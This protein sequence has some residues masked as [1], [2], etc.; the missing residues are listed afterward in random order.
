M[1]KEE[2]DYEEG[3]VDQERNTSVNMAY[4]G[5]SDQDG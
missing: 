3:H 2:E 1:N 5:L 4:Q